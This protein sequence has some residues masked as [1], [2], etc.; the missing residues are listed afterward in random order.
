MPKRVLFYLLPGLLV[1]GCA[2]PPAQPVPMDGNTMQICNPQPEQQNP[3]V[4]MPRNNVQL[5]TA[6]DMQVYFILRSIIDIVVQV[7]IN[8]PNRY[9]HGYP[10]NGIK[11]H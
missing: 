8:S 4:C 10:L 11:R 6:A 1:A 2:S 3:A 5:Q 7:I 9:Q